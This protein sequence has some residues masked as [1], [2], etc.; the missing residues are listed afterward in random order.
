MNDKMQEMRQAQAQGSLVAPGSPPRLCAADPLLVSTVDATSC[1][2]CL[3][4]S[5]PLLLVRLVPLGSSRSRVQQ[6][7]VARCTRNTRAART[8]GT[9]AALAARG[10]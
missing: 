8:P 3:A 4:S 10:G 9:L 2:P 6:V 1:S 7:T 5:L